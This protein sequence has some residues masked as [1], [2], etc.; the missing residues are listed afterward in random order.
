MLHIQNK[1]ILNT[2]SVAL[3]G[4]AELPVRSILGRIEILLNGRMGHIV[5]CIYLQE[6]RSPWGVVLWIVA[7]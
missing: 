6:G 1:D 5:T 4:L 2:K 7:L 3:I